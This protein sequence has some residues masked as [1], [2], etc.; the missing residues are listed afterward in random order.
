MRVAAGDEHDV[1]DDGER[2][3]RRDED[4]VLLILPRKVGDA[5]GPNCR[6][7]VRRYGSEL[8][9]NFSSG[10]S[11]KLKTRSILPSAPVVYFPKP[12][13]IVGKKRLVP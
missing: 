8:G 6:D 2:G 1:S 13:I 9:F 5:D 3:R 4:S 12:L 11:V 7:D 10:R